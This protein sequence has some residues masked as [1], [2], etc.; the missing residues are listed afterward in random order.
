[1]GLCCTKTIQ[2]GGKEAAKE[3]QTTTV[4]YQADRMERKV[5]IGFCECGEDDQDEIVDDCDTGPNKGCGK[6]LVFC[7][8]C[9]KLIKQEGDQCSCAYARKKLNMAMERDI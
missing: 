3:T 9:F 2:V 8:E 6:K 4:H 7:G 5:H 1:M